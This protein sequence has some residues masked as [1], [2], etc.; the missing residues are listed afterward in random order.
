[1]DEFLEA[2]RMACGLPPENL[3]PVQRKGVDYRF[4]MFPPG[5]ISDIRIPDEIRSRDGILDV[6]I[7]FEKGQTMQPLQTTMDRAGFLVSAGETVAEASAL[8]DE[9]ARN[10]QIVY[11]N[12]D[13][14]E[15]LTIEQIQGV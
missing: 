2:C 9:V 8:A 1:M 4:L 7:T 3:C 11:E 12:G 5:T 15:P 6:A 14:H 13:V 10:I